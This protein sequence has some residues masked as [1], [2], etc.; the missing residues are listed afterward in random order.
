M[1]RRYGYDSDDIRGIG[2]ISCARDKAAHA[3]RDEH[4][5]APVQV[6]GI[7]KPCLLVSDREF[8]K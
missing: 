8:T 6:Q 1:R 7:T 4:V 5:L 3:M 2:A